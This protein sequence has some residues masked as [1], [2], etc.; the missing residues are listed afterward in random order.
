[1]K[2]YGGWSYISTILDLRS[3]WRWSVS[4]I[5][6]PLFHPGEG[7][8]GNNGIWGWMDPTAVLD[9]VRL[10]K[11]PFFCRESNPSGGVC[12][13]LC[14]LQIYA[15]YY[16]FMINIIKLLDVAVGTCPLSVGLL[17]QNAIWTWAFAHHYY[18]DPEDGGNMNL[19]NVGNTI[20]IHSVERHWSRTNITYSIL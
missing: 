9:A 17:E 7:A 15:I 18:S 5:P 12:S 13:L 4:F 8:P 20:H 1:M 6:R 10:R 3:V 16:G 19:R 11:I 2:T 14:L